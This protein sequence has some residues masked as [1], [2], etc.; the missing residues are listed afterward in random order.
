MCMLVSVA[1][2][3]CAG[4]VEHGRSA[5][6]PQGNG[7]EKD[8]LTF[9][10]DKLYILDIY[11]ADLWPH[12]ALAKSAIDN[13]VELRCGTQDAQYLSSLERALQQASA[14]FQPDLILYN[15]GTD[16]LKGDPLG[17]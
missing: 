1:K 3:T 12:D 11:N 6:L 5:L 8:K 16:I 9:K 2:H 4:S 10:D 15:A 17:R 14:A 13:T 7:Y